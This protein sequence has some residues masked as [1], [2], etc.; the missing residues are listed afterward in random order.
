MHQ[1]LYR[2]YRPQTFSDVCGQDHISNT[3][4]AQVAENRFTHAYL[5][6]GSRGTGKTSSAKILSKAVNCL[7]PVNG[8]PCNE[9]ENCVG[10][11]NGEIL[12]VVEIDAASNRGVDD[13]RNLREQIEYTPSKAK[14]RV[15]IIDEVH[16]LTKEAFNALL[17]TLEEPP[18]HAIFILATTEVWAIPPTI[19][20]RCQRYDFNRISVDV[21]TARIK[22]ICEK[23]NINIEDNAATLIAKL[24]DGGMRDALSLLDLCAGTDKDITESLVAECAGLI[25]KE[26]LFKFVDIIENNDAAGAI[27]LLDKLYSSSC[28]IERLFNELIAHYRDLLV[29]KTSKDFRRL[30]TGTNEDINRIEQQA[31]QIKFESILYCTSKLSECLDK[32]KGGQNKRI[33]AETALIRL[34]TNELDSSSQAILK[35]ISALEEKIA[36]GITAVPMENLPRES[37]SQDNSEKKEKIKNTFVPEQDDNKQI[38]S[39]LPQKSVSSNE[40]VR[41]TKWPEVM[42]ILQTQSTV[43]YAVLN[44]SKAYTKGNLLLIDAP[45]PTFA[46]TIRNNA[47]HKDAIRNAVLKI[48]GIKYNL[49]PYN[50]STAPKVVENDP[51]NDLISKLGDDIT[52][53]D[54]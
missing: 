19:L 8:D 44:N 5:F 10:I 40:V 18:A 38:S 45:N 22:Y 27:E 26:H 49:G 31:K 13:I 30:I 32:M 52:I 3:L 17:K 54:E 24:C 37:V 35:R 7:H 21:I 6:T 28:D 16:M 48:T 2:K 42:E 34:C 23:E 14:F 36:S 4:K 1:A 15:Y 12:D 29:A 20:S 9:C 51:L 11:D 47:R 39:E 53:E 41:F 46:E 33:C 50:R 43:L 25:G